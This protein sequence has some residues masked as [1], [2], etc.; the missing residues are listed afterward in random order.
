[1][2]EVSIDRADLRT[3][4]VCEADQR[5]VTAIRRFAPVLMPTPLVP[6]IIHADAATTIEQVAALGDQ[7]TIVLWE[8]RGESLLPVCDQ[9]IQ[10]AAV[11]PRTLQLVAAPNRSVG[12]CEVLSELP[13][14]AILR[15]PEDLAGL[16]PM[17]RAYF[18]AGRRSRPAFP[19]GS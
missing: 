17:V 12:E 8:S 14:T 13:C 3:W 19:P 15:H 4:L 2:I 9:L 6:K 16:G 7:P 5:W 18:H 1:M 11:N 10:T